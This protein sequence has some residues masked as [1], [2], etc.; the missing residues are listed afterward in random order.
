MGTGLIIGSGTA[1]TRGGPLGLLLGYSFVGFVCYLVMVCYLSN[2]S[3]DASANNHIIRSVLV[4]W[5]PFY[6]TRKASPGM[7]RAS[8]T[9]LSD[10]H[11][12]GT[13]SLNTSLLPRTMSMLLVLSF[14]TGPGLFILRYGWVSGQ[15]IYL[16]GHRCDTLSHALQPYSLPSVSRSRR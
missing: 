13:I 7:R 15:H 4:K 1:L 8:W 10:L 2:F 3:E 11:L 16:W 5:L 9:P 12:D 14:N 6:R